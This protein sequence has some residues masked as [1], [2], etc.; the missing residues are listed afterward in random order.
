MSTSGSCPWCPQRPGSALVPLQPQLH[1]VVLVVCVHNP[2][3]VVL[4]HGLGTSKISNR[5]RIDS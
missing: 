2:E 4:G 1:H 3:E 5:L